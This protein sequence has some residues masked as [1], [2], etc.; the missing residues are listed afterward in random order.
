MRKE[1]L[2]I[3]KIGKQLLGLHLYGEPAQEKV[4][5]YKRQSDPKQAFNNPWILIATITMLIMTIVSL[6][7]RLRP[8]NSYVIT[9]TL[10]SLL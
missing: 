2:D 10:E 9:K 7:F 8:K 4:E 5:K 3:D 1:T 6:E